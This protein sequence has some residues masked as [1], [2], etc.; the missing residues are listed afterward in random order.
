M[1]HLRYFAP[2]VLSALKKGFKCEFLIHSRGKY[3]CVGEHLPALQSFCKG[4]GATI[5]PAQGFKKTNQI[6]FCVEG[7]KG[8][9]NKFASGHISLDNRIFVLTYQNDFHFNY[10]NY[11][12][13]AEKV[14]I[15]SQYMIDISDK[16]KG[17]PNYTF[18][19]S[20]KKNIGIGSPKYDVKIDKKEVIEK[21]SLSSGSKA[22]FIFPNKGIGLS[23]GPLY[24]NKEPYGLSMDNLICLYQII[25][26]L[27]IEIL[28]KNRGK[29]PLEGKW[30]KF[31]GDRYFVDNSWYP[32]TTM[33]LIEVSDFIINV[34]STVIKESVL[35]RT[36]CLNFAL[37]DYSRYI[38][39]YDF[40][41]NYPY[42]VQFHQF[43]SPQEIIS[44]IN[45][46]RSTDFSSDFDLSISRHLF[47][48]GSVSDKILDHI[49][50]EV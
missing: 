6:I 26:S 34:D 24:N 5:A 29:H 2:L 10:I 44:S 50:N 45:F 42:C 47:E 14:F 11:K 31:K 36:P 39:G 13:F 7:A 22:L 21:Y 48:R 3:N 30:K 43:P 23:S 32:H 17:M 15:P 28:V 1:T 37:R 12:D 33:E 49:A 41:Y 38:K 19:S 25:Q 27:G 8:D 20:L 40:L 9:H 4:T 16:H 18:D 35:G 46:L